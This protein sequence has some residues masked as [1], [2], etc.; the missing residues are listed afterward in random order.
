M[1]KGKNKKAIV[2][3][4]AAALI[5]IAAALFYFLRPQSPTGEIVG[6]EVYTSDLDNGYTIYIE[7]AH[8]YKGSTYTG[9]SEDPHSI[10]EVTDELTRSKIAELA[11]KIEQCR[12]FVLADGGATDS[13][14]KEYLDP[15]YQYKSCTMGEGAE[16]WSG[17]TQTQIYVLT[18][19]V[20]Y[21]FMPVKIE[22]AVSEIVY[23]RNVKQAEA[24]IENVDYIYL[25][26]MTLPIDE[27]LFRFCRID[28]SERPEDMTELD[29]ILS[30][31]DY[32]DM[33]TDS[34][35]QEYG[36]I[37]TMLWDSFNELMDIVESLDD[38]NSTVAA[39]VKNGRI[40]G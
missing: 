12:K 17:D 15:A 21:K 2:F 29:Y 24:E 8:E 14:I 38:S 6:G 39:M 36:W 19:G 4:A 9:L 3:S 26:D 1:E 22:S 33:F 18:N 32:Q 5:L 10:R 31:Y 37:S 16:I 13:Y 7:E 20:C 28:M 34:T 40:A 23:E 30:V 11:L 25:E 27:P 35:Q